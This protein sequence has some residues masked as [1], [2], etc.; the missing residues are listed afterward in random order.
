[1]AARDAMSGDRQ[2]H[3]QMCFRRSPDHTPAERVDPG[4]AQDVAAFE[5]RFFR[6]QDSDGNPI[7]YNESRLGRIE[8]R[9]RWRGD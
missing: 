3:L 4:L 7:D 1:M 9:Y 8:A 6:H 5:S 2:A